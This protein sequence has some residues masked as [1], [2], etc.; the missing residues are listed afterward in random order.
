MDHRQ[1]DFSHGVLFSA[2]VRS[3]LGTL[4][5]SF[6]PDDAS[7]FWL[8]AS[9]SRSNF[10]LDAEVVSW[11]L[12]AVL[13]GTTSLFSVVE[14]DHWVLKFCVAS[15]HVG[16][17]IYAL[18]AFSC[19]NFKILFNLWNESGLSLAKASVVADHTSDYQWVTAH[20]H[21]SVKTYA[22]VVKQLAS[23]NNHLTGSNRVPVRHSF[24]SNRRQQ[25]HQ[26]TR[27]GPPLP[28]A[29]RVEIGHQD[30]IFKR[31]TFPRTSA[32]RG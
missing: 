13:G 11:I 4:V 15:S 9:F 22:S 19:L 18:K 8:I 20:S 26:F 27:N 25:H 3:T 29:N 21:R 10:W 31:I 17:M 14:L 28:G 5:V 30:S 32:F 16:F 7:S 12:E 6:S 1:L 23:S 24:T 2:K